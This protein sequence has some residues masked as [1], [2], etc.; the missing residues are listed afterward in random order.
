[1]AYLVGMQDTNGQWHNFVLAHLPYQL[2]NC[3]DILERP[4]PPLERF[5]AYGPIPKDTAIR[6][7]KTLRGVPQDQRRD[8]FLKHAEGLRCVAGNMSLT[9]VPGFDF[10]SC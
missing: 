6:L 7:A 10:R 3:T 1:M 4:I 2:K 8:V 5:R 9:G